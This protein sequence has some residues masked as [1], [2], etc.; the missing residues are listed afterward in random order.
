MAI[1][2]NVF[3]LF[4]LFLSV[5]NT[6]FALVF[7]SVTSHESTPFEFTTYI[8]TILFFLSCVFLNLDL[9]GQ[10]IYLRR[11]TFLTT[12]Y[13]KFRTVG[14]W[15]LLNTFYY[16]TV[17]KHSHQLIAVTVVCACTFSPIFLILIKLIAEN[18]AVAAVDATATSVSS[19]SNNGDRQ[20]QGEQQQQYELVP[21]V[22]SFGK[23]YIVHIIEGVSGIGK[24]TFVTRNNGRSLDFLAYL[25]DD[26][27]FAGKATDLFLQSVYSIRLTIDLFNLLYFQRYCHSD[28]FVDRGLIS[29]F[30]YI[31]IMQ[32][33]GTVE[34]PEAFRCR[35]S[36]LYFNDS[37]KMKVL[38][39]L[40]DRSLQ[41]FDLIIAEKNYLVK[42][43]FFLSSNNSMIAKRILNRG[44]FDAKFNLPNYLDN[45]NWV[46]LHLADLYPPNR[47]PKIIYCSSIKN[48]HF[49]KL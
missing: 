27:V 37:A 36:K 33:N 25:K 28:L 47:R 16:F 17:Y 38:R 35:V 23:T 9:F 32:C 6:L 1:F 4:V 22:R 46:F 2:Q 30:A 45:S 24:T 14:L 34:E 5:F 26:P 20:Q 3:I 8:N 21:I 31:I 19:S 13:V 43:Y 12:D 11:Y 39:E 44:A 41:M 7:V 42:E 15:L 29:Q 48:E 18:L 10:F 49:Y 40:I